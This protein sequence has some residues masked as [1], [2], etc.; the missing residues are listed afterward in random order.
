MRFEPHGDV[1]IDVRESVLILHLHSHVNEEEARRVLKILLNAAPG[2]HS[3]PWAVAACIDGPAL[4]TPGAEG[5]VGRQA[6]A[7]AASALS[8]VAVISL[9]RSTRETATLQFQRI[10]SVIN[11]RARVFD[12]ESDAVQRLL[13]QLNPQKAGRL[14]DHSLEL[15][16]GG[17]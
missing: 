15:E 10:L 1:H 7:L 3:K 5:L 14:I 16:V 17:G 8:A 12:N 4:L 9:D 2:F 13:D 6:S 11:C